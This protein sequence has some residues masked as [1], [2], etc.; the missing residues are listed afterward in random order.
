[1]KGS[2][3]QSPA[4][5]K[6]K[7]RRIWRPVFK[8][9]AALLCVFIVGGS[10]IAYAADGSLPGDPLYTV[11]LGMEELRL[12]LSWSETDDMALLG[13]F[14]NERLHEMEQLL[15]LDRLME[16]DEALDGYGTLL[17]EL[18]ERVALEKPK[19]GPGASIFVMEQL[20]KNIAVLERVRDE[21]PSQ[22][23]VALEE[24][25]EHS[26]HS[27]AVMEQLDAG[28]SPSDIAPGQM[29]KDNPSEDAAPPGQENKPEKPPRTKT[30]GPPQD[31]EDISDPES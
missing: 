29:K 6:A 12:A 17:D 20:S 7:R 13:A 4:P 1:M 5:R 18:T 30:P 24:A 22:A 11:K 25:I 15:K 2:H 23:L 3:S 26:Q 28:L 10:G 9:I 16:V 21:A 8:G 19:E 27:R 14:A 31:D